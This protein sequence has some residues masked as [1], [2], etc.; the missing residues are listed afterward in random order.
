MRTSWGVAAIGLSALLMVL[1]AGCRV[2]ALAEDVG[3]P[4][5][6]KKEETNIPGMT[7]EEAILLALR[8]NRTIQSAYLDRVAQ[9][10]DLKVAED[11]FFPNLDLISSIYRND[12]TTKTSGRTTTVNDTGTA[13]LTL[14]ETLPTGG[15]LTFRWENA[16]DRQ[17]TDSAVSGKTDT[18]TGTLAFVQ[19]LLKGGGIDV[20]TASLREARLNEE[21]NILSLKSTLI[22]TVTEV[23]GA[24]RDFVQAHQEVEISRA[25]LERTRQLLERNRL[26]IASGRM[27]AVEIVQVEADVANREY[28]Y[29]FT[30]NSVDKA[31]LS[32]LMLL[33]ID[34]HTRIRPIAEGEP[35]RVA[36]DLETST[37]LALANR[38]AYGQTG[39]DLKIAQIYLR[40]AEN[41]MLW[42]L[43]LDASYDRSRSDERLSRQATDT[44]AWKAGLQL[45]VPIYGDL[46]RQ[47]RLTRARIDVKKA[48]L[49]LKE[50]RA[51][52]EIE[53]QD[54]IREVASTW[55]QFEL[56]G[57]ALTLSEQK[58]AIEAEKLNAGLS[59][60]FQMVTFQNDL[61]DAQNQKIAAAIAYSNALTTL[62]Q[63]IGTTLDTWK[64]EFEQDRPSA[65]E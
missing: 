63:A 17:T 5:A 30:L 12:S 34:K 10:F 23:V 21:K 44:D 9:K 25:S 6:E 33:D 26:L 24:F 39:A 62:D 42:D 56:A 46:T 31:R 3:P 58:L 37:R 59:N 19:P 15:T 22:D 64:I 20:N 50:L 54:L 65:I 60:N 4:A 32:L 49:D 61:L 7:I 1:M 43:S 48:K 47:Q 18:R 36:P 40:Q 8:H 27:A 13:E 53:I 57:R 52:I 11:E 2:S 45:S 38:P 51:N 35:R 55:R 29:Q 16:L 41:N 14:S 28:E